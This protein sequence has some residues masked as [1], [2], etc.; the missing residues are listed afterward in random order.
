M[1]PEAFFRDLLAKAGVTIDGDQP[2]DLQ[3]R[4]PRAYTRMMRDGTIGFGEAFMDGWLDC[5]RFDQL[6]E[7]AFQ[8]D[9]SSRFEV[10]A[11]I[12]A[13]IR[14]RLTP[15][16]SRRRSFEIGD[17]HYDAGNDFFEALLDP[18]MAYSCGYWHNAETLEA[19]QRAKLDLICRKL[20]LEPGIRVLDIGSGWGSFARF[21]AENYGANVVGITVSR[22]QVE[23]AERF[24]AGLPA[25][26]RYLDYRDI[27]ETFD[28]VV[29]VGMFEH[30]GRRYHADFFAACARC[31]KPSGLLLLH[32]IGQQHEQAVN[33]WYDKYIAPGAEIPTIANVVTSA[34]PGLL[35]EDLHTFYGS[36]YDRTLMAWAAN[37]D[38]GWDRLKKKY[39]EPFYR[40]WKLYLQGCAAGFRTNLLR[41]WQFVFSRD[42]YPG[43]YGSVR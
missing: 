18:T 15:F 2:W 28:R 20:K 10:R 32:T 43:G 34:H 1:S 40:M 23:F 39:P 33:A 12:V 5:A 13:S 31:L 16:G 9:L 11:A 17:L 4:D 26:F 7:R 30:V 22:Q 42:G 38:A 21:A 14:A 41:V 29:S 36:N 37:L 24:C 19:A 25:T 8:A 3:V 35:L 6:A 27:D